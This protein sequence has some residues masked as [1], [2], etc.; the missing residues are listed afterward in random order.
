MLPMNILA[1]SSSNLLFIY[2]VITST[3][4]IA[5]VFVIDLFDIK[6]IKIKKSLFL[7]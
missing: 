4:L 5:L 3:F 1:F 6:I 2:S 7:N